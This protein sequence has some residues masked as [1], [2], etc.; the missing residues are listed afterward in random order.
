[1]PLL[2]PHPSMKKIISYD[3][4]IVH[5]HGN[6]PFS[7]LGYEVAKLKLVPYVLTFHTVFTEY[8]HY[9]LRGKIIR[10]SMV[11]KALKVFGNICDVVVTPSE[12]MRDELR[13]YG[14]RKRIHIMRNFVNE[15]LFTQQK[16]GYLHERL[17]LKPDVPILLAV[18]RLAREKNFLFLIDAFALIHK[19]FPH[20]KLVI[21]GDG[22]DETLIK[23]HIATLHLQEAVL[24]PG[25]IPQT[26][27]PQVYKDATLFV[28][29][30]L[31]ENQPMC[32]LEAAVSGLPFVVIK[33]KAYKYIIEDGKNGF[34]VPPTPELFA[35]KVGLLLTDQKLRKKFAEHSLVLYRKYFD[36]ELVIKSVLEMY[37]LAIAAKQ[38]GL[39][40]S[41]AYKVFR[42]LSFK[43]N[44]PTLTT[45]E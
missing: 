25:R 44:G 43:R 16:T 41:F 22:P 31:T 24:L 6:G 32:I 33:D 34:T 3:L 39:E 45:E 37:A 8:T 2:V 21:V 19:R 28:F 18:G 36:S 35:Q 23:E 15:E 20:A 26:D 7:F 13:K 10:P 9:I 29:S 40:P 38:K 5:A 17:G 1:M 42:K 11:A 12:K 30:S 27:M 14:V 4:D